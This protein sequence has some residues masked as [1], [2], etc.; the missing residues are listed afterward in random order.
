MWEADTGQFSYI[1][2]TSKGEDDV[3]KAENLRRRYNDE[4]GEY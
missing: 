2:D 1:P 3:E 4:D